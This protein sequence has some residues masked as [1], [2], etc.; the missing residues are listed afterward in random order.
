MVP[1]RAARIDLLRCHRCGNVWRPR[2]AVVRTCPLCKSALWDLPRLSVVRP[3]DPENR[4]WKT[5]VGPHRE[6]ILRLARAYGASRVRVFGSVRRGEANRTSDLDLLV[7][8]EPGRTA[9]D[10]VGLRQELE[11]RLHRHVDVVADDAIDWRLEPQILAE[12]IPL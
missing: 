3:F 6:E 7:T 5:I 2:Q 9:Y 4:A 10:Q 1:T 8:F 12:A 11:K